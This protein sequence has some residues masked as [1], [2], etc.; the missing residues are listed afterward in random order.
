MSDKED[1]E[2]SDTKKIGP[3]VLLTFGSIDLI[4]TLNLEKHD[5]KKY[6]VKWE[7]LE[8]IDNLK[9]IRKHK[10]F[11][12]RIE[13][14]SNNDTMNIILHI[15]KSSQ[16][17]IK[18]GYIAF[19]KIKYKDKQEDFENLID[20]VTTQN[21]LFITSCDVCKCSICVQLVLKYENNEKS[22]IILGETETEKEV[23]GEDD[24]KIEEEH[25]VQKDEEKKTNNKEEQKDEK[26]NED[27]NPFAKINEDIVSPRD[28]NYIYFNYNDYVN[29]EFSS[30]IKIE[31]L[32]EYI[33]T[34]KITTKSKIIL[35]LEEETIENNVILRDL[36]SLVDIFIFYDKNKL[37]DILKQLKEIEDNSNTEK[38]YA[39]HFREVEKK[40]LEKEE[41]RQKEE[42]RVKNYKAFLE[43]NKNEKKLKKNQNKSI[44]KQ[45]KNQ[46]QTEKKENIY[47]TQGDD[48]ENDKEKKSE[49]NKVNELI[50]NGNN[51]EENKEEKKED[52]KPND[53]DLTEQKKMDKIK[54]MKK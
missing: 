45:E 44:E 4:F 12:K 21:G 28:F 14:S 31:H 29:G 51:K 10:H 33:Q 22:F 9:F 50:N 1:D 43:R 47:I 54:R 5:L 49:V 34:L 32:Y 20:S 42:E 19:E 35:N 53:K 8:T 2:T 16:K 23:K 7:K 41:N 26:K 37:Y 30:N 3:G 36:L 48:S 39:Y 17:L 46:Q 15:N 27:N 52:N 38:L 6:K 13:L 11:W 24:N 18:I 25:V 40:N